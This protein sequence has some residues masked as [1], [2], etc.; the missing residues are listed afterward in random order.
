MAVTRTP[1]GGWTVQAS[2]A[3]VPDAVRAA[4]RIPASVPGC[5]HTDLM[6]A[7][8]LPDPYLDENERTQAW[9]GLADWTYRAVL[10]WTPDGSER[11][12]LV[13][14]GID[15]V[16]AIRLHGVEIATT[17]NMHRTLRID[18]TGLLR[19]GGNEIEVAIA[20]PIKSADAASLA[21]GYRPHVN[22][23]P[24]NAIRKMACSFGWDWGIDTST[25]GLWRPVALETWS[26]ARFSEVRT[27][28]D[29]VD[30]VPRLRVRAGVDATAPGTPEVRVS[31]ADVT[32]TAPV[33]D[34]V[35][36][37][38]L[39]VP[40]AALWWPRG[41]GDPALHDA[42][43]DLV[44]AEGCVDRRDV[45]VG[46]RS[47]E[48][49][50][51]TDDAG[52]G[53]A[54]VVNGRVVQVRGAN[55]IPDDAFP[56]RVDR[57][58]YSRRL[59]QAEFARL[60][61]IRV[62]GGGLYESEDFYAECDERGLLVWQDFLLACAAY[63]EEEPLRSEI[64]AEAREATARLGA[65]PALV[66]LT[67][68][69][70]NLIGHQD[71][72][73]K[74]RLERRT[75]GEGYYYG[76]FPSLVAEI[77]PHVAYVPGSPFSPARDDPQNDP[78]QGTVHI[79][80]LWNEKDWPHYRDHRPRFVAEFGWQ[81][82]PTWSTLV[83]A[84]SDDPLTPESPG[85]LV[86]Q[87]AIKGNDHLTDGLTAHLP[88]PDDMADWHWAMSVNQAVAIRTAVEWFRSLTP[89]CTGSIV[90]Q[91][92]DCWPVTSWAAVD[93]DERPKPLLHG[94]RQANHPRLLTIQP[95]DG[96]GLRVALV[97]DTAEDWI[98]ELEVRRL[99]YGGEVAA[100]EVVPVRV[101]ARSAHD[102]ALR[103][104]LTAPVE[105]ERELVEARIDD[106]TAR[107]FFTDYR[108]SDLAP[109]PCSVEASRRGDGWDLTITA[110]AVAREV[111]VLVD[112][113]HPDAVADRALMTLLRGERVV[114]RVEGAPDA[115][116][117]DFAHP[118]V[119]RS[120]NDVV[121]SARRSVGEAEERRPAR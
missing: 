82:P 8:L 69:N 67:G 56:H 106:A 1:I 109:S 88:L 19:P 55:W 100:S 39:A 70:E 10:P 13:F 47:A 78:A 49:R 34:G 4:E 25:S 94:L 45:R 53:F 86:H 61:L 22:H 97:N 57:A 60:N 41:H 15:T 23:H 7:G 105:P 27:G 24:Y 107:W 5:V 30:G 92:N 46:F 98:G 117:S 81:G 32:A 42:R 2:G 104:H 58:R 87:K 68:N 103:A 16:A 99:Q 36:V 12:V 6:D 119:L 114:V 3:S 43:V 50:L 18:V 31:V 33:V 52:V 51:T 76:L 96:D 65:H 28:G 112:R 48:V 108:H 14:E 40:D 89:H 17:R 66:V 118:L 84:I 115:Q 64:E 59:D 77:A 120:A 113:V 38:D 26:G 21:L 62:W 110:D 54:I 95:V 73:W 29:V 85:M 71:W 72:G 91:L 90:W 83:R 116:P 102:V 11:Q 9:V 93:G 101:P 79:W 63:A 44:V 80:D 35:A 111:T 74:Q 121:A 20:S 37:L 75:W